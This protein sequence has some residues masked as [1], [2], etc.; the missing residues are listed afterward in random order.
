MNDYRKEYL[1]EEIVREG[2]KLGYRVAQKIAE[3]AET[4]GKKVDTAIERVEAATQNAK[5]SFDDLRQ[6]GWEGMKKRTFEYTRKDPFTALLLAVGVGICL[7][8]WMT[9]RGS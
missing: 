4:A 5:Q 8:C 2:E 7:G 9:K 6:E 1:E 3:A